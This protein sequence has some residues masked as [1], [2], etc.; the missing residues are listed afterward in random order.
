MKGKVYITVYQV[1]NIILEN[2]YIHNDLECCEIHGCV[3]RLNT[4]IYNPK[5]TH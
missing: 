5:L 3:E 2:I 1:E 4:I